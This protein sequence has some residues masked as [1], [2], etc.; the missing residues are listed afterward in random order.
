MR[1]LRVRG[2][3]PPADQLLAF[4]GADPG[5]GLFAFI[6]LRGVVGKKDDSGGELAGLRK[7]LAQF[8]AGDSREKFVGERRQDSGA[9]SG[10]LF[11]A[12]GAAVVHPAQQVFGVGDDVM[13]ALSLDVGHK[14]DATALVLP[15]GRV[16]A[17]CRRRAARRPDVLFPI[18]SS[19][20]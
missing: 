20:V 5:H 12:A 4:L 9:V 1:L 7:I 6:P 14:T 16:Q 2:H 15:V 10:G 19:S 13:A 17:M 3:R 18:H 11:G 8:V